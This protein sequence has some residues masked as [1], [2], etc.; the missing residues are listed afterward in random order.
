MGDGLVERDEGVPGVNPLKWGKP[1]CQAVH[2][3]ATFEDCRN[4][5][6]L[7]TLKKDVSDMATVLS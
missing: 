4:F 3:G 2:V 7:F 6:R 1:Q 5:S